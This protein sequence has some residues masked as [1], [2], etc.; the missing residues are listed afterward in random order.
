MRLLSNTSKGIGDLVL[1]YKRVTGLAGHTSRVSELME[2][3]RG[4][5]SGDENTTIT[6]LYLR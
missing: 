4:L 3:I 6:S 2:R 1:V 5:S